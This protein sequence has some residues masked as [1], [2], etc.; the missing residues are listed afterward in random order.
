MLGIREHG[1]LPVPPEGRGDEP[2]ADATPAVDAAEREAWAVLGSVG[3]VGP[4]TFARL[5]DARGTASEVLVA[6]R[7]SPGTGRPTLA[8][9][10]SPSGHRLV[11][12]DTVAA[13]ADASGRRD[14]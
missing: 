13:I 8:T 4:A 3:G 11:P 6:A 12:D 7:P 9:L 5:V 1:P 14:E 10:V 2:S